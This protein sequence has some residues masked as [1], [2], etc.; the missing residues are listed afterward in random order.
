MG[1]FHGEQIILNHTYSKFLTLITKRIKKEKQK[2]GNLF[3]KSYVTKCN[4]NWIFVV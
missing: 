4:K 3:I 2:R 1:G